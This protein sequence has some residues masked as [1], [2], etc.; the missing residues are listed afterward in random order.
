MLVQLLKMKG[1][2]ERYILKENSLRKL[3]KNKLKTVES[4]EGFS[5]EDTTHVVD[6]NRTLY[7]RGVLWYG[8][9][10]KLVSN[11][12]CRKWNPVRCPCF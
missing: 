11:L 3:L 12:T 2:L 4:V 8:I 9:D 6:L 1:E 5:N 7:R 10:P